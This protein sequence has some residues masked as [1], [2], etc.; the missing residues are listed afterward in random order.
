MNSARA[1]LAVFVASPGNVCMNTKP[2]TANCAAVFSAPF[3]L[4]RSRTYYIT[5]LALWLWWIAFLYPLTKMIIIDRELARAAAATATGSMGRE[6]LVIGLALLGLCYRRRAIGVLKTNTAARR[7]LFLLAIYIFWSGVSVLWSDD[8]VITLR[9]LGMLVLLMMGSIGLGAGFYG[10]LE[11]GAL[12]LGRHAIYG[13]ITAVVMLIMSH[14][15]AYLR[16]TSM[17]SPEWSVK[18][19]TSVHFT[20]FSLAYGLLAAAAV[21]VGRKRIVVCMFL[22]FCLVVLKDRALIAGS[23]AVLMLLCSSLM[24]KSVSRWLLCL[25]AVLL[26][27]L[28]IDLA[29]GGSVFRMLL[30][31]VSDSVQ[32]YISI[33]HGRTDLMTLD[34]RIPLWRSLWPRL[35]DRV[36]IGY[37]FGAFWQPTRFGQI[38]SEVGWR[39]VVA[40]NGFLDEALGTG[41]IALLLLL[42]FWSYCIRLSFNI[43]RNVGAAGYLTFAWLLVFLCFNSTQ[44]LMQFYFN[45]PMLYSIAAIFALMGSSAHFRLVKVMRLKDVQKQKVYEA[46]LYTRR[47]SPWL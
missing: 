7:A 22:G 32:R 35:M 18:E 39:A 8:V 21:Y 46:A 37:G 14:P 25:T 34:G 43:A 5:C 20:T 41:I 3:S 6:V 45:V 31:L 47:S 17:L 23:V 27:L 29:L 15:I 9:R 40:H 16:L 36:L 33:G 42:A 10:Q 26:I 38:F 44:S 24:T 19:N 4:E 28:Q 2:E 30:N 1:V 13:A 12:R 11:S